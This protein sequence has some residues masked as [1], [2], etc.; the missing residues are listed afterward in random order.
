MGREKDRVRDRERERKKR[1]RERTREK[2]GEGEREK[3]RERERKRERERE[4]TRAHTANRTANKI[5]PRSVQAEAA[6]TRK[7]AG[8]LESTAAGLTGAT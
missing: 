7:R 1:E 2:G 4:V 6:A 3:E 5:G 8:S